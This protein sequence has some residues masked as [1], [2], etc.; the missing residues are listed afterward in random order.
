MERLHPAGYMIHSAERKCMCAGTA[1]AWHH[2][3]NATGQQRRDGEVG[4][5]F[6]GQPINRPRPGGASAPPARS[7]L[8]EK[9]VA[10]LPA[11]TLFAER[12]LSGVR[13]LDPLL[14]GFRVAT[15]TWYQFHHHL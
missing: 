6:E 15:A 2:R 9:R 11:R 8:W 1:S 13:H 7:A 5:A 12:L 10:R 14:V 3:R 4:D